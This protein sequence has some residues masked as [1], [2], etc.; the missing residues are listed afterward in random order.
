[1]DLFSTS[2]DSHHIFTVSELTNE[3]KII[4]ETSLPALWVQGE[5]SNFTHHSS[6]HMYFSLKDERA[7]I[8]CTMWR[9]RNQSLLFTPQDGMKV[10]AFGSVR[11]YEKRGNYQLDVI[12][13]MPAGIGELQLAFEQLKAKLFKEGLFDEEHKKPIPAYPERIG[14]ITSPTGAAIR[15]ILNVIRRRF[16]LAELILR[17]VRVQGDGAAEEIAEA[18]EEMNEYGKVDVLIVGR[19]GGSLEDL[20]AFNEEIVARA[21]YR[22]K[23]PIISAVGHE[24]DFTIADFVADLRAPTPSAA[25]EMV[26]PEKADVLRMLSSY[27]NRANQSVSVKIKNYRERLKT[28]ASSYA[29]RRPQDMLYQYRQRLDE[30]IRVATMAVEHRLAMEKSRVDHIEKRLT[31]LAPESILRRGY[32]ICWRESDKKILTSAED[33]SE[34]DEIGLHFYKGGVA[35]QVKAVHPTQSLSEIIQRQDTDKNRG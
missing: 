24:I 6:G 11:V 5:I 26:V 34:Q 14:I 22:S 17:P 3:I 35:A 16:P 10:I 21:I 7:Q 32:S 28:I 31:S 25:S 9:S 30:L 23:I 33:V 15:D 20:W 19:G 1:M 4:L 27:L 29:F 12:K 8:S 2:E 13:M 18:I